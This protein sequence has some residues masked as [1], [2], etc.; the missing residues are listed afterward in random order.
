[1]KARNVIVIAVLAGVVFFA[2]LIG[3]GLY[4]M[5]IEDRYM[6]MEDVYYNANNGDMVIIDGNV[7]GPIKIYGTDVYIESEECMKHILNF[8]DRKIEVYRVEVTET[9]TG[10]SSPDAAKIKTSPSSK[11]IFKN[12]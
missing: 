11:L 9:A 5:S 2:S 3:Y 4:L 1:M 8:H 12:F 6:G 7:A 10:N